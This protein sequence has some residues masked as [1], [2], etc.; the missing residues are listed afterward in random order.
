M[1]ADGMFVAFQRKVESLAV[2]THPADLTSWHSYHERI[3]R[4]VLVD[5]RSSPDEGVGTDGNPAKNGAI[6]AEGGALFDQRGAVFMLALDERTRIVDIGEHHAWAAKNTFFQRNAIV[7]ANVILDFASVTDDDPIADKNVLTEGNPLADACPGANVDEVPDTAASADLRAVIDDGA[8]MN[9]GR[10]HFKGIHVFWIPPQ[11]RQEKLRAL[12][13]ILD[14]LGTGFGLE[15]GPTS[16]II[17][18]VGMQ[19]RTTACAREPWS[20]F[21][22]NAMGGGSECA[23]SRRPSGCDGCAD[24]SG[25]RRTG[26][27][28]PTA[29]QGGLTMGRACPL[30]GR[31]EHNYWKYKDILSIRS[32]FGPLR[33]LFFLRDLGSHFIHVQLSDLAHQFV[34]HGG[35]QHSGLGEDEDLFAKHHERGNGSDVEGRG[36]ALLFFGVDFGE[37]RIGVFLGSFFENRPE[38][39]TGS[40]PGSPKVDEDDIVIFNG[41]VEVVFGQSDG[42]H[43]ATPRASRVFESACW[44]WSKPPHKGFASRKKMRTEG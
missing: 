22:D 9:Q 35:W 42:R 40:T 41:F 33:F 34:E 3:V 20:R 5:H 21:E 28:G 27:A 13:P 7:N 23:A 30:P 44:D 38:R 19:E 29:S 32:G 36:Q 4:H 31:A 10:R 18:R 24:R 37:D 11:I 16:V 39:A 43:H 12:D 15:H 25:L 1:G 8:G 6:R 17:R 2:F 14:C 26:A